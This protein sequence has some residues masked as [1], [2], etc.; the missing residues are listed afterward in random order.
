[1]KFLKSPAP[2][3]TFL[4]YHFGGWILFSLFN[5]FTMGLL[6]QDNLDKIAISI[7]TLAFTIGFSTLI[8]REIIYRF[9][10]FEKKWYKQWAYLL[11]TSLVLGFVCACFAVSIVYT[12]YS[13]VGYAVPPS[14]WVATF[15]NWLVLTLLML[16]WTLIYLTAVNQDR[17]SKA[18]QDSTQLKLQLNEVK[19]SALMGQLNPH[20]LFNGLNNIRALILEDSSKSREMLTNLSDLLRYTLLAHKHK[21]VPLRDELEIVCQYIELLKIQYEDRLSFILEVNEDLMGEQIP[22]LLIQLLAENAIRHGIEKCKQGGELVIKITK[23][24]KHMVITVINPGTLIKEST[25][26]SSNTGLGLINIQKRLT[27]Q[28]GDKTHFGIEQQGSHVVA[29]CHIPSSP[30]QLVV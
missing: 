15:D 25:K 27:I 24:E 18:E 29:Q 22:T 26:E 6:T 20:F 2:S 21:T 4:A 13:F 1:M 23:E 8:I 5:T 28:Y 19:M 11:V 10:L 7:A 30:L 3:K 14:F 16:A 12:Y 17:L 9:N